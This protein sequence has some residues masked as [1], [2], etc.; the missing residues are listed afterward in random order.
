MKRYDL[1][2][3]FYFLISDILYR[4]SV[5]LYNTNDKYIGYIAFHIDDNNLHI[6]N[7]VSYFPKISW[8]EF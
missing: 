1:L 7:I 4:K 5:D 3:G 8:N 6:E 2:D